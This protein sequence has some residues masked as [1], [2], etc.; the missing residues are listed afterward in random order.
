ME[1][2]ILFLV[3]GDETINLRLKV[4]E[5]GGH[6]GDV[7]GGG[8]GCSRWLLVFCGFGDGS[9]SGARLIVNGARRSKE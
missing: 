5:L 7:I 8:G 2:L 6:V 1:K 4:I 9:I 3:V